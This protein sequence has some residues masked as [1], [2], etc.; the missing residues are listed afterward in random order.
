MSVDVQLRIRA[1]LA[2]YVGIPAESFD[3][4]K[5][6]DLDYDIDS[7]ELTEIAKTIESEIAL[8]IDKSTRRCWESGA[9]IVAFVTGRPLPPIV[10]EGA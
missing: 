9:G 3:M 7:T 5:S 2:K 8:S 1:I 4:D 6:L 10:D